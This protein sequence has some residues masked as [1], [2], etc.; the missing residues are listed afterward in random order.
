MCAAMQSIWRFSKLIGVKLNKFILF[1]RKALFLWGRRAVQLAY[2][3]DSY[4][5]IV[6]REAERRVCRREWKAECGYKR[7]R[8]ERRPKHI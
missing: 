6:D 8:D 7:T 1:V 5:S 3:F 4:A 2:F